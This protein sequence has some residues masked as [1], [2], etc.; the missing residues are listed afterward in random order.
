M[1]KKKKKCLRRQKRPGCCNK[2]K[3]NKT[4]VKNKNKFI[5]HSYETLF[6]FP[7]LMFLL[8]YNFSPTR[9]VCPTESLFICIGSFRWRRWKTAKVIF[10]PLLV[11]PVRTPVNH[12]PLLYLLSYLSNFYLCFICL[13]IY[14]FFRSAS[15][16]ISVICTFHHLIL[17]FYFD[18]I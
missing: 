14:V 1:Q 13:S 17:S 10:L 16:N 8:F 5:S 3:K 15:E 18:Y 7:P 4:L 12:F 11:L 6:L 2:E 9:D